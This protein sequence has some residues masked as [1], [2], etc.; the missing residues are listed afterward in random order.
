MVQNLLAKRF[1]LANIWPSASNRSHFGT[2]H[3]P[4]CAELWT[5]HAGGKRWLRAGSNQRSRLFHAHLHEKRNVL[6]R[7]RW[8]K[9]LHIGVD[10]RDHLVRNDRGFI[11]RHV[12]SRMTQLVE[13]GL[14][15]KFGACKAR[16]RERCAI[17]AD[18]MTLIATVRNV[19]LLSVP[20]VPR[21]RLDFLSDG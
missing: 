21:R 11:G 8:W 7:P 10:V 9:A 6:G 20:D 19:V 14:V 2:H 3:V 5:A 4:R 16:T 13:E 17:G 1:R 18:A 12:R 15:R